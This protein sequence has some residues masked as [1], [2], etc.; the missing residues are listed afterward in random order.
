VEFMLHSSEF[1]P[2]GSPTF[3]DA[4]AVERLYEHLEILFEDLSTWCCGMTLKE[5]RASFE[6]SPNRSAS[7]IQG[8]KPLDPVVSPEMART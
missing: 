3:R 6:K 1:M 4:S 8:D 5:F 2:G 7:S